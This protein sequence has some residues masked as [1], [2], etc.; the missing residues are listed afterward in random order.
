VNRGY[1]LGENVVIYGFNHYSLSLASKLKGREVT[2]VYRRGSLVHEEDEILDMGFQALKGRITWV[3]GK[4]RLSMIRTEG[5]ELK[6]D[7]LIIAE[8]SPW[9]PLSFRHLVGNSAMIVE[10]P[11]KIVAGTLLVVKSLASNG[12][13]VRVR[14]SVPCIPKEVPVSSPEIMLDVGAGTKVR[15]NGRELVAEEPY[16]I[17]E[18][19]PENARVEVVGCMES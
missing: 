12:R 2:F 4:K 17:V 9:N 14:C 5:G 8:L 6:A 18:V 10:D 11:S 16:P 1:E 3:Q 15:I 13:K 19:P 7:T